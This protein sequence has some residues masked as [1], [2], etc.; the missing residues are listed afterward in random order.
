M[1]VTMTV[2]CEVG[3]KSTYSVRIEFHMSAQYPLPHR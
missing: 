2:G 1:I 3:P